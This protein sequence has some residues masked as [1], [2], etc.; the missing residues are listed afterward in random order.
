MCSGL[1][2]PKENKSTNTSGPPQ[3]WQDA[4][5]NTVQQATTVAGQPYT[6]Y[7]GQ[8]VADF[9]A[10]QN[11]AFQSIRDSQGL[12]T[13]YLNQASD[14]ATRGGAQIT[15]DDINRY[16]NPYIQSVVDATQNDFN[17]QNQREFQNVNSNAAKM[18]ALTG[19]RSQV[20]NVLTQE[21]QRR[22]QDPLIAGLRASGFDTALGAAQQDRSAATQ[23]AGMFSNLGTQ[24]QTLAA[25]DQQRLLASGSLQQ[26]NDQ[27]GLD[28]AYQEYLAKMAYPFESTQWLAGIQSGLM[29]S[30]GQTS[31]TTTPRP[32][33]FSQI[34]GAAATGVG[35]YMGSDARIKENIV[36]VGELFDGTP[37]YRYNLA[38]EPQTQI[39]VIAQDV[40]K[41]NPAAVA[42][43]D[44]VLHVDYD[45]ATRPAAKV[46]LGLG[47]EGMAAGGTVAS[48]PPAADPDFARLTGNLAHAVSALRS[49]PGAQPQQMSGGGIAGQIDVA[50]V[51]P[52]QTSKTTGFVPQM[53]MAPSAAPQ[54][55]APAAQTQQA[56][57][58]DAWATLGRGLGTY[59]GNSDKGLHDW[60]AGTTVH[61]N[62]MSIGGA[63]PYGRGPLPSSMWER[64]AEKQPLPMASKDRFSFNGAQPFS[65]AQSMDISDIEPVRPSTLEPFQNTDTGGTRFIPDAPLPPDATAYGPPSAEPEVLP[66]LE[67]GSGESTIRGDE[68]TNDKAW[69]EYGSNP[70]LG[71]ALMA[72]G[73][74]TM[75]GESPYPLINVGRG[76]LKGMQTYYDAKTSQRDHLLK[77]EAL[78]RQNRMYELQL[79]RQE[80]TERHNRE[81]ERLQNSRE[82]WTM[83][84]DGLL[85]NKR[86]GEIK[87]DAGGK[88]LSGVER[89]RLKERAKLDEKTRAEAY[90]S[91]RDSD[92]LAEIVTNARRIIRDDEGQNKV[93]P[94]LFGPWAGSATNNFLV[95]TLPSYITNLTGVLSD[96][97]TQ[98]ESLS[99]PTE[100]LEQRKV[101]NS[102]LQEIKAMI[103]AAQNKGQGA[104]SDIE[105]QMYGEAVARVEDGNIEAAIKVLNDLAQRFTERAAM[106]R[107]PY[108]ETEPVE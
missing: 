108:E 98:Q 80:E 70:D 69:Y 13:P 58:N 65:D 42:D 76:G 5:W 46:A 30:A 36:P 73:L 39:G 31:T 78:E 64:P 54:A 72:A 49:I 48:A 77:K 74:A 63:A 12:G 90:E 91:A 25:N 105:R 75:S 17:V 11:A 94:A 37:I 57:G 106:K 7:G 88:P 15:G 8:R 6:P 1:F 3:K 96:M 95:G 21:S 16:M 19:D 34:L 83:T 22:Q 38:G 18:G 35:A 53:Q 32:S 45:V 20:A 41:T 81:Q 47:G 51:V 23:A 85:M 104:V 26:A 107:R 10:D 101:I 52:G 60:S 68:G 66:W 93:D 84:Q 62:G 99:S 24:A 29:P 2:G 71:R 89:T 55:Q 33:I 9:N 43:V 61:R 44:G 56:A 67:G 79:Q 50:P 4:A 27:A 28:A 102:R 100:R 59:L 82:D 103:T 40:E 87:S 14:Y 86:T 97:L 92:N